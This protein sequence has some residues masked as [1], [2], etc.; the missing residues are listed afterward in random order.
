[1]GLGKEKKSMTI[2]LQML[3]AKVNQALDRLD[4][5][6]RD[7]EKVEN[8][9]TYL[10]ARPHPWRKQLCI[11]GRNT[12]VGQL[13]ST[14]RVNCLS[15]EQASED[16]DL[17]LPAILEALA[18]EKENRPLLDLEIREERRRLSERGHQLEPPHLP[19]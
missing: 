19:G 16:L 14:I 10:V 5:L 1:M 8:P 7:W 4:R 15:P 6:E 13:V 11:K 3:E 17:P 18:Y 2:D 12:T 9:W